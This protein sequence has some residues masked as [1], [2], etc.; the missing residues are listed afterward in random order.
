MT[1]T[2]AC[3]NGAR[4]RERRP[5]VSKANALPDGQQ[6]V[7]R[8]EASA[9]QAPSSADTFLSDSIQRLE[10]DMIGH[11]RTR[12]GKKNP[13]LLVHLGTLPWYLCYRL[14]PA[15]IDLAVP[16]ADGSLMGYSLAWSR[17]R[18]NECPTIA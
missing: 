3:V 2:R 17:S 8:I 18:P 7:Q 5:S 14:Y 4:L 6:G 9:A 11:P 1:P 16:T 10:A 15:T 12:R 13:I